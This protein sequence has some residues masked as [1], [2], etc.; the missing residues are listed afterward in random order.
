MCSPGASPG[1]TGPGSASAA[2]SAGAQGQAPGTGEDV[3]IAQSDPAQ[4]FGAAVATGSS[5]PGTG[6][7]DVG[8]EFSVPTIE[9]FFSNL[10]NPP[11]SR[12]ARAV[13][14]AAGI[15][16][17]PV[18]MIG[19]VAN[20]FGASHSD[21]GQSDPSISADAPGVGPGPGGDG[22]PDDAT[23]ALSDVPLG[24]PAPTTAPLTGRSGVSGTDL[25]AAR[26]AQAK[27][28]AA[29]K[30]RRDEAEAAA[31][32]KASDRAKRDTEPLRLLA[33]KPD[34][35]FG[36]VGAL[37]LAGTEANIRRAVLLGG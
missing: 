10:V 23:L 37:G 29:E 27:R 1:G 11:I 19:Q 13:Q 14:T 25:V 24:A 28:L 34:T 8:A 2:V 18:G 7:S 20:A 35:R 32:K 5:A 4:G 9:Q 36:N 12:T 22:G 6:V 30:K 33:S 16:S 15:I 21:E 3:S 26:A 31:E 17:T